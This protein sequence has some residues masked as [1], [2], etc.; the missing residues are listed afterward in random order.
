MNPRT[1]SYHARTDAQFEA[2]LDRCVS[3]IVDAIFVA[4]VAG[5]IGAIYLLSK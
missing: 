1:K 3:A 2:F 5:G 4:L